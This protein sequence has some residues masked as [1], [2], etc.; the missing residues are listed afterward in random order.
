VNPW[1]SPNADGVYVINL[2]SDLTIRRCRING[3]LVI[4]GSG[5]LVT[6]RD[7]VFIHPSR[8]DYP[9]IITD[10]DLLLDF[11][12]TGNLSEST[13]STNFNPAGAPYQGVTDSDTSDVYP[14]EIQGLVHTRGR[15]TFQS[16]SLVRG[17][18]IAESAAAT[19]AVLVNGTPQVIYT[20]SLLSSP[21]MGYTRN[22][23]MTPVAGTW[24]QVVNP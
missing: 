24:T 3:T 4:N 18:I 8:A 23:A 5:R 6:I 11:V 22:I 12:G 20:P 14:S 17:V 21:P 16:T 7:N 13:E 10:A 15:L 19:D 2:T 9:T 1:G